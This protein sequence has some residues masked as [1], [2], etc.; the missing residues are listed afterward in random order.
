M[1]SLQA[2]KEQA[3]ERRRNADNYT[4]A[5]FERMEYF[6]IGPRLAFEIL[7]TAAFAIAYNEQ[8]FPSMSDSVLRAAERAEQ[9][10]SG[11]GLPESK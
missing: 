5:I 1:Y 3:R 2:A 6:K 9:V 10:Y 8:V 7:I 4:T 11:D